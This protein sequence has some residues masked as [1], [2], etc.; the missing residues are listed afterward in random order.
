MSL[1]VLT[2]DADGKLQVERHDSAA[3]HLAGGSLGAASGRGASGWSACCGAGT[4]GDRSR[5]S[6]RRHTS[7]EG[8][9]LSDLLE[10]GQSGVVVVAVN[11]KESDIKPL[12]SGSEK[13]VVI[14]TR[15]GDIDAEFE[16]AVKEAEAAK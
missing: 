14:E 16:K 15:A 8:A 5:S 3:G 2:K 4:I 9:E 11:H 1:A 12:L 13:S 10:S 6:A 7:G